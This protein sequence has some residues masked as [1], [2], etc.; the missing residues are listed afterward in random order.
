MTI[1]SFHH[2]VCDQRSIAI[3]ESLN[4]LRSVEG[5]RKAQETNDPFRWMWIIWPS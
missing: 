3:L 1:A 2:Q 4:V 5:I